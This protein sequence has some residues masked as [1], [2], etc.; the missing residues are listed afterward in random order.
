[1]G[2]T[3]K[4]LFENNLAHAEIKQLESTLDSIFERAAE[5]FPVS[6]DRPYLNTPGKWL[7]YGEHPCA[8]DSIN[9]EGYAILKGSWGFVAEVCKAVTNMSCLKRWRQ[10][11]EFRDSSIRMQTVFRQCAK[12]FRAQK[13]VYLNGDAHW[14]Y[15]A[16]EMSVAGSG[17]DDIVSWLSANAGPPA[18]SFA[19]IANC[20]SKWI[21]DDVNRRELFGIEAL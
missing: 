5:C 1:M 9:K 10:F 8:I 19:E 16:Y 7:L 17:F 20:D 13:I 15:D 3:I 21:I 12:A 4:A 2:S 6:P 14:F 18:K 11:T